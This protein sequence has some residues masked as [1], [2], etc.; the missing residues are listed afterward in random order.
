VEDKKN[1]KQI[2]LTDKKLQRGKP[3]PAKFE[4]DDIVVL[5]KWHCAICKQDWQGYL[6]RGLI[7]RMPSYVTV[8]G[9]RIETR[10]ADGSMLRAHQTCAEQLLKFVEDQQEARR[11]KNRIISV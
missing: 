4:G 5:M 6:E 9:R 10:R 3:S 11:V 2:V 1:E 7:R 8:K